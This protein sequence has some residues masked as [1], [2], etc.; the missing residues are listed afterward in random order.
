MKSGIGHTKGTPIVID[1]VLV[2]QVSKDQKCVGWIHSLVFVV[3]ES[4]GPF[5]T[6]DLNE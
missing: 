3:G 2:L 6:K 1:F 5:V 4:V